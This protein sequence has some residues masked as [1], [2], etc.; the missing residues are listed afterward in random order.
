MERRDNTFIAKELLKAK[1]SSS[2]KKGKSTVAMDRMCSGGFED[3]E[4]DED[5]ERRL[6]IGTLGRRGRCVDR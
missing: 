4:S 6:M 5:V 2:E 1:V 3:N